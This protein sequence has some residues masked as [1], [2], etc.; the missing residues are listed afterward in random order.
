MTD[1]EDLAT[2]ALLPP[3]TLAGR[4][5][6]LIGIVGAAGAGKSSAAAWL[7]LRHQFVGASFAATLKDMLEA[8]Y[9]ARGI[10]YIYLYEPA[11]KG[12][13]VPEL[14]VTTRELM[15]RLGDTFRRID[16]DWWVKAL[17]DAL[18]MRSTLAARRVPVHDRIVISDVRY[19]NEAGWVRA[20]GGALLRIVRPGVAPVRTHSSE[21]WAAH[22]EVHAEIVNDDTLDTLHA[23]LDAA[24]GGLG[25]H[26]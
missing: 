11:L 2:C 16:P 14:G 17:A 12:A 10:D 18:G 26:A 1:T 8:H 4:D 15:Q 13:V 19:P 9:T 5:P 25:V 6:V 20:Q 23:R 22:L 3:V 24:L 7:E 21:Q